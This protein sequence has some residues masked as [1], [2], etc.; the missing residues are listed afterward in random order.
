MKDIEG[1]PYNYYD[2]TRSW[3]HTNAGWH[4]V[5]LDNVSSFKHIVIVKWLYDRLDNPE[6]HCRWI[7]FENGSGFKFRYERDC[8][9]FKL[10]WL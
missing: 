9:L 5:L 4:E 2:Y 6:R 1:V 8:I 3:D 10:S 7:R